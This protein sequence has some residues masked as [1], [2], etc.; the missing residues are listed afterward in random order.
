MDSSINPYD[1]S[2]GMDKISPTPDQTMGNQQINN[3]NVSSQDSSFV[4]K[5]WHFD[6]QEAKQFFTNWCNLI[7]N[8]IKHQEDKMREASETLKQSEEG[9][10]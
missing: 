4:Q 8:E 3:L 10:E 7:S 6:T 5:Y 1:S 2:K 9:D